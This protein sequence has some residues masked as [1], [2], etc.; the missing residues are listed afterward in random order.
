MKRKIKRK[1]NRP[2]K[3][4]RR[5]KSLGG[6]DSAQNCSWVQPS[7]HKA[8]HRLFDNCPPDSIAHI[9][10]AIWLDPSYELVVRRRR[11]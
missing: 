7:Q 4:H 1:W 2:S 10:N 3:H 8:W 9:I 6:T 5:P 11:K